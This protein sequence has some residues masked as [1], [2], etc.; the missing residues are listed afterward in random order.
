MLPSEKKEYTFFRN[1]VQFF[2]LRMTESRITT[3]SDLNKYSSTSWC[4]QVY[5]VL[6]EFGIPINPLS[7]LRNKNDIISIQ[8]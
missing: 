7:P 5:S 1:L 8:F 3:A 2:P 4:S 6:G